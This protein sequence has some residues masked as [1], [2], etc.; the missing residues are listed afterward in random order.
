MFCPSIKA[1]VHSERCRLPCGSTI[2]IFMAKGPFGIFTH[3]RYQYFDT[4]IQ[5]PVF[6]Y[7]RILVFVKFRSVWQLS[8][9][10]IS[11]VSELFPLAY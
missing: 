9:I 11:E 5:I 7:S 2:A 8:N 4:N 10:W 1:F 6:E 3:Y